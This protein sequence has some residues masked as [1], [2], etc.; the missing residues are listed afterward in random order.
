MRLTF[1]EPHGRFWQNSSRMVLVELVL[2]FWE[3]KKY[4]ARSWLT[5]WQV[6]FSPSSR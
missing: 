4:K 1:A 6:T 5:I 3:G 2:V